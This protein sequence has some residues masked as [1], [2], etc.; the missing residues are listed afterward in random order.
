MPPTK[1]SAAKEGKGDAP[2]VEVPQPPP[3]PVCLPL[4]ADLLDRYA[5]ERCF[6]ASWHDPSSLWKLQV[7]PYYP[8]KR[9]L[10]DIE[11]PAWQ[12]IFSKQAIG[13]VTRSNHQAWL[14]RC[15]AVRLQ[16]R[17]VADRGGAAA[18]AIDGRPVANWAS[19]PSEPFAS[20]VDPPVSLVGELL[21]QSDLV[22]PPVLLTW[23]SSNMDMLKRIM[24]DAQ[25]ERSEHGPFAALPG[26]LPTKVQVRWRAVRILSA[27]DALPKNVLDGKYY[28]SPAMDSVSGQL[29][30]DSKADEWKMTYRDCI[31]GV[32]ACFQVRVGTCFRWSSWSEESAEVEVELPE[33]M[34]AALPTQTP[35]GDAQCVKVVCPADR[36]TEITW[37]QFIRP[38]GLT[39]IEYRVL[40][41]LLANKD[42]TPP[43]N[44]RGVLV[45]TFMVE[46]PREKVTTTLRGLHPSTWYAVSVEAR[47]P[48]V[49]KRAFSRH[50]ALSAPFLVPFG[51]GPPLQPLPVSATEKGAKAVNV[52]APAF[53]DE[54]SMAEEEEGDEADGIVRDTATGEMQPFAFNSSSRW[55]ALRVER[56]C[57]DEYVVE[58]KVATA[59]T[60]EMGSQHYASWRIPAA[61]VVDS[62]EDEVDDTASRCVSKWVVVRVGFDEDVEEVVTC[63]LVRKRQLAVASALRWNV[64]SP[65]VVP[66]IAPP[67]FGPSKAVRARVTDTSA[68]LAVCFYLRPSFRTPGEQLSHIE[69]APPKVLLHPP[70]AATDGLI[71][72][73]RQDE[74]PG[75]RFVS[76]YQFRFQRWLEPD[77]DQTSAKR[78]SI[79]SAAGTWVDLTPV[80]LPP[81][82]PEMGGNAAHLFAFSARGVPAA[83]EGLVSGLGLLGVRYEVDVDLP[84]VDLRAAVRQDSSYALEMRIGNEYRWSAWTPCL[85]RSRL[86]VQAPPFAPAKQKLPIP[87]PSPVRDCHFSC[88]PVSATRL[89]L[90]WTPFDRLPGVTRLEYIIRGR[91]L[92][93]EGSRTQDSGP[94]GPDVVERVSS[95]VH[96]A[97]KTDDMLLAG[98]NVLGVVEAQIEAAKPS[99]EEVMT[100][101]EA[102]REEELEVDYRENN[103]VHFELSGLLPCTRYEVT[104]AA[105]YPGA[106]AAFEA[107]FPDTLL[108]Q[109]GDDEDAHTKVA[110]PELALSLRVSMEMPGGDAAP[111]APCPVA[112]PEG[113]RKIPPHAHGA[114]LRI[115]N[116]VGYVLEYRAASPEHAHFAAQK[117]SLLNG[118]SVDTFGG[119]WQ[120]SADMWRLVEA[121]TALQT[122]VEEVGSESSS[123][124]VNGGGFSLLWAELADHVGSEAKEAAPIPDAVEFRLRAASRADAPPCRWAGPV[125]APVAVCFAPPRRRPKLRSVL[126]DD[127]WCLSLTLELFKHAQPPLP[128]RAL[129]LESERPL[130]DD[131][132]EEEDDPQLVELRRRSAMPSMKREPWGHSQVANMPAGFG[133]QMTSLVQVRRSLQ[134]AV[135][136]ELSRKLEDG[137]L[138]KAW[139]EH[140]PVPVLSTSFKDADCSLELSGLHEGGVYFFQT[141]VGD[142]CRWSLWSQPSAAFLYAVAPPTPPSVAALN[143]ATSHRRLSCSSQQLVT[144]EVVSSTTA[145]VRWCDYQPAPGLTQLEYQVR[146]TP[147]HGSS[148]N[149]RGMVISEIFEHRYRGGWLER[150]ILDLQ[151]FTTYVL[152]VRARYPRVGGRDWT[153]ELFSQPVSLEHPFAAKDPS[154]PEAVAE[155]ECASTGEVETSTIDGGA[156][157][158]VCS[159]LLEFPGDEDGARYDLEFAHCLGDSPDSAELRTNQRAWMAP[160]SVEHVPDSP[161]AGRR[162]GQAMLWR[163]LLPDLQPFRSEPL[164]L[165]LLQRVRFRLRARHK[166]E[167][168]ATRWWSSL[169]APVCTGFA[170]PD[171]VV[172]SLVA[173]NNRLA[174]EVR[175]SM[176]WRLAVEAA[177]VGEEELRC[178]RASILE[179]LK[180]AEQAPPTAKRRSTGN[181]QQTW[182]RGFGHPFVTRYQLRVRLRDR[183]SVPPL[184]PSTEAWWPWEV[185]PDA[186]LPKVDDNTAQG[187]DDAPARPGGGLQ[188]RWHAVEVPHAARAR[189]LQVGDI[190]QVSLRVGDGTKWSEWKHTQ[191]LVFAVTLPAPCSLRDIVHARAQWV[192]DICT[193]RWAAAAAPPGLDSI[194]YKLIVKPDSVALPQRTGALLIAAAAPVPSE[195]GSKGASS[196]F[197]ASGRSQGNFRRLSRGSLTGGIEVAKRLPQPPEMPSLVSVELRDLCV[198]VCYSFTVFARYPAVGPRTFSKI[199]DVPLVSWQPA[200]SVAIRSPLAAA[201]AEPISSRSEGGLGVEV[202]PAPEQVAVPE[203]ANSAKRCQSDGLVVL[204]WLGLANGLESLEVQA[205]EWLTKGIM[206]STQG[207]VVADGDALLKVEKQA[208]TM[209]DSKGIE[210]AWR[211]CPSTSLIEVAGVSC[212]AVSDLQ[213]QIARFRLFDKG[214]QCFG[215]V[216]GPYVANFEALDPAPVVEM[217]ALGIGMPRALAVHIAWRTTL[218][219]AQRHAT[220]CQVRFRALPG[221]RGP[222]AKDG[223][224]EGAEAPDVGL[225]AWQ[226]LELVAL[227]K[228]RPRS[229]DGDFSCLVREEDGLE[230]GL[231]YKFSVRAG[232]AFR[233]SAWSQASRS[234]HFFVPPP[235]PPSRSAS[236]A[237]VVGADGVELSWPAFR[238]EAALAA[239]LPTFAALPIE[240]MLHIYTGSYGEP[241]TTLVTRDTRATV[242]AMTP[243]TSYSAMLWARWTRFGCDSFAATLAPPRSPSSS[244]QDTALTLLAAFVTKH[245]Q[246]HLVAEV[247]MRST[248]SK[249]PRV[250]PVV[251]PSVGFHLDGLGMSQ[252]AVLDLS[253]LYDNLRPPHL[254]PAYPRKASPRAR[255]L[256]QRAHSLGTERAAA[257]PSPPAPPGSVALPALP[258]KYSSR[259]AAPVADTPRWRALG[260]AGGG[261][262]GGGQ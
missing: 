98:P 43:W 202:P 184:G 61:Q 38:H 148:P 41:C 200:P 50:K 176:D 27:G 255:P 149:Q 217:Q 175:F 153:G 201:E 246:R 182:P 10:D 226:E 143:C 183:D 192:G 129:R 89:R 159:V 118:G 254:R 244:G 173:A 64:P 239:R 132:S 224:G 152:S 28:V 56:G 48:I 222:K 213:F 77:K 70:Q 193:V 169:S 31:H 97:R 85:S 139:V 13:L 165:A 92:L 88:V 78:G 17:L 233:M 26:L 167:S 248:E 60:L 32:V 30:F 187:L 194:E 116:R 208:S 94:E 14:V 71:A 107:T 150:E 82:C 102:A 109:G 15:E 120:E 238:P 257:P 44:Q 215:P 112:P 86:G 104:V 177:A 122:D 135:D 84:A 20:Y 22:H 240:Y 154:S 1:K 95:F 227:E 123:S 218:G 198:D 243:A 9:L 260:A 178:Q 170:A 251:S 111:A 207:S 108:V 151:P 229:E 247:G 74:K 2:F 166:A 103:R 55:V 83:P 203:D 205:C 66:F 249:S 253:P 211:I 113:T 59:A 73:R 47:Y 4:P 155:A 23:T 62:D 256:G 126:S 186:S 191:E 93:Q 29:T 16:Y 140:P 235:V 19:A 65:P 199:F 144:V 80:A 96:A 223:S 242:C 7:R 101:F 174:V 141:R 40:V 11:D 12:D 228:Q 117:R 39:W 21:C 171:S 68:H 259:G 57:L 234:L 51:Q 241:V 146:A 33:P 225:G 158:A 230:L 3:E 138:D 87:W 100:A 163:V 209:V 162:T 262:E 197:L 115:E 128:P 127:R 99:F 161:S 130:E 8:D 236:I 145:R 45:S 42:E 185:H 46:K 164:K 210:E 261:A 79:L 180:S 142:G 54:A 114:V 37:P 136:S 231:V 252:V 190:V 168:V 119:S 5:A 237:L 6:L 121:S 49:G 76:R 133:H 220:R 18:A 124:R 219:G 134:A 63:C 195:G 90:E 172:A 212:I 106:S 181:M 245:S 131:D 24:A 137:T 221:A 36:D 91:P 35:G 72:R 25:G 258:P 232:D 67:L 188:V 53:G 206:P 156:D 125:S 147:Q 179:A 216:L 157:G 58:Y 69:A 34:P 189:T 204:T 160:A 250:S 52:A 196:R 75:H 81:A 214:S 110:K 105:R